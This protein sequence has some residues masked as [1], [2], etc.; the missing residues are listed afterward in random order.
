ML[1]DGSL[2]GSPAP[3]RLIYY[4][5]E[6]KYDCLTLVQTIATRLFLIYDLFFM[7]FWINCA[8]FSFF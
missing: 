1:E 6:H 5:Q 8:N 3:S 7:N 4:R 2:D